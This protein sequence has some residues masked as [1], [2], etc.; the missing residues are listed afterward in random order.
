MSHNRFL[1]LFAFVLATGVEA[2]AQ[3]S[4]AW[5]RVYTGDGYL[6]DVNVGSLEFGEDRILRAQIRTVLDKEE[7]LKD[8]PGS[9]SKTRLENIEYKLRQGN[10]RI[11]EVVHLDSAGKP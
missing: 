11:V 5:K 3:D 1:F 8:S 4:H 9:K 2:A 6:I 10:Y 7:V